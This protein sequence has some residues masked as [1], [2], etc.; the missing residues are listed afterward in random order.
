MYINIGL[1]E[2]PKNYTTVMVPRFLLTGP[3]NEEYEGTFCLPK[4][5]I[6]KGATLREGDMASIQVV[7]AAQHGATLFSIGAPRPFNQG[8]RHRMIASGLTKRWCV[9]V[10]STEDMSTVPQVTGD[11][12]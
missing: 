11:S 1:G 3:T 4:V 12:C 6:P 7:Q 10:I 9:D 5:P 2:E 8:D